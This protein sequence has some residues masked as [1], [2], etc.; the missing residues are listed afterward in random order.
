MVN[1]EQLLLF[2]YTPLPTAN[3]SFIK[4]AKEALEFYPIEQISDSE[5][6]AI[7]IGEEAT[8]EIC[9]KLA[10]FGLRKLVTLTK[11]DFLS[12]GLS[13][14]ASER[15]LASFGLFKRLAMSKPEEKVCIR[16]S[17]Y[18]AELVMEELRYKER[19]H[20]MCLFLDCKNRLI[21]KETIF[22]GTL[23]KSFASPREVF[24]KA[25]IKNASAII[26][27]HNHPTGDPS[28]SKG[29]IEVTKKL[30]LVGEELN[31][32]VLDHIIIG[33]GSYVSLLAKGYI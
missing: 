6:L 3:E 26:C 23:N 18:V 7:L 12:F 24:Q 21:A 28:P 22:I 1:K 15:I 10:G 14:E 30:Q 5:L 11:M 31:I 20:F 25:L 19:E 4:K 27:C 29:D 8:S 32:P 33:D 2:K 13:E 16:D 9:G 17:K